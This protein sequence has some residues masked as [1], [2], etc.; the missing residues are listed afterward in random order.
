[1]KWLTTL[2]KGTHHFSNMISQDTKKNSGDVSEHLQHD[3]WDAFLYG[4]SAVKVF[5]NT[6]VIVYENTSYIHLK[7][8]NNDIYSEVLGTFPD[9]F[10]SL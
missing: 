6:V 10:S 1:M 7:N 5:Q 8:K 2:A 9:S 4:H 3:K